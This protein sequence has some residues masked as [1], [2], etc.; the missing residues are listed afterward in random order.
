MIDCRILLTD[1]HVPF[2]DRRTLASIEH[3]MAWRNSRRASQ[4]KIGGLIH[5][6]DLMDFDCISHHNANKLRLVEARRIKGDYDK[7]N[8]IL[9]R[10]QNIIGE[11]GSYDLIEGNH[12][13]RVERYLDVNPQLTGMV[14]VEH[15]LNLKAR[16][17]RWTRFWSKGDILRV[18]R[19]RFIH[20]RY[21][22]KYHAEKHLRMYGENTFYG[23]THDIQE[24][25][26]EYLGNDKTKAGGSMGCT[27]DYKQRYLQGA[28]TKWQQAFALFY[29]RPNGFFNHFI[30]RIFNH[31]FVSPEGE[32]FTPE[33]RKAQMAA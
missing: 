17:F 5:C 20:G 19:A 7:A 6:G 31:C 32:L 10:W 25:S 30:V 21:T 33:G 26:Q 18:G 8:A 9:D 23:H 4:P 13:E 16:G 15:G 14:E 29:F 27:C 11:G 12:E 24:Y 28:P 2:E 1:T 3:Y 22:N